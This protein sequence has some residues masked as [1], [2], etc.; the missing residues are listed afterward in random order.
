MKNTINRI[1]RLSTRFDSIRLS[2]LIV[3]I[4]RLPDFPSSSSSPRQF[5][6]LSLL[7]AERNYSQLVEL[8]GMNPVQAIALQDFIS[9]S[10]DAELPKKLS[11]LFSSHGSDKSGT[12]NYFLLYSEI[13]KS[14]LGHEI[15]I[16]EIGIGSNNLDTPS[17]MGKQGIPGAS[18]RSFRDLSEKIHVIG[19]DIDARILFSEDRIETYLLDQ[20]SD[21]SWSEFKTKISGYKFDLIIDDGLHSPIANLGTIRNM[22]NRLKP[23]G[24]M[25]IEDIHQR[26][27]P[28]WEV[29]ELLTRN[30]LSVALVK[31]KA[32]YAVVIAN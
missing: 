31:T 15:N 23:G 13:L 22:L 19:A 14:R 1:K 5:L 17:N 9:K 8:S 24:V 12:H 29:F 25:V 4:E 7:G 32:A 20:L 30:H 10:L 2:K 21:T 16:L 11:E 6:E 3:K 26:S 18:L 28:V 27:L